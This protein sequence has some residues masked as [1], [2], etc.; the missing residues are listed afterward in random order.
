MLHNPRVVS[1]LPRRRDAQRTCNGMTIER[2]QIMS[3]QRHAR[4]E[5]SERGRIGRHGVAVPYDL[6][7]GEEE[8]GYFLGGWG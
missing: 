8:L 2:L 5:R 7:V 3:A 6:C 1:R 4:E